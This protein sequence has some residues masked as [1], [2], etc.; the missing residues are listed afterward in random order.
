MIAI[1]VDPGLSGAIAFIR[2]Q[3]FG[4]DAPDDVR[5]FDL[6]TVPLDGGGTVTRRIHVPGLNSLL[7]AN[8]GAGDSIIACIEALSAGGSRPGQDRQ[9]SAQTVGSQY[10]TRG[11]I[12]S[13]F[14]LAG[15][16]LYEVSAQTWKAM[17][18]FGKEKK[19][20]L[21]IARKLYPALAE[22]QLRLALHHNRAEAVLV[23]RWA[24]KNLQ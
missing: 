17:Y 9:S 20:A 13:V 7:R 3:P 16:K 6:P 14:D 10:R 8:V 23:A 22:D 21:T 1:G 12:E 2:P 11:E 4:S 19:D 15:L 5:V 24:L 18:G